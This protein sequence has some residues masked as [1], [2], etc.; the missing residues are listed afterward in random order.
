MPLTRR[1]GGP[2]LRYGIFSDVHGNREALLAVLEA[3]QGV[4]VN[5]LV[6]LGD[7]VG[8]GAQPDE[9]C[10]IVRE[11]AD[12]AVVGNHDAAAVGRFDIGYAN[13]PAQKAIYYTM[14]QL[15]E[16]NRLWLHGLPYSVHEAG[17]CF[18]HGAPMNVETF[19]YVFSLDKAAMLSALHPKLAPVTFVGHSHLTTAFVVTE[20]LTLQLDHAPRFQLR[21]GAKYVFNVG[22]V[23][24]PRDRDARACCVIWDTEEATVTFLRVPYDQSAAAMK[25]FEAELPPQ[26]GQRLFH[27]V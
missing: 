23:G 20:Q 19:E 17:A 27:G 8:Y 11:A 2:L 21:S 5:R 25:I 15:S 12:V 22:S 9:C 26:F 10:T 1:P 18:C 16:E 4:G 3:M 6:N 13:G 7:T 24:Q 14:N